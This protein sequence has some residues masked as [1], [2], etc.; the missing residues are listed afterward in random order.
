MSSDGYWNGNFERTWVQVRLADGVI[1][2]EGAFFVPEAYRQTYWRCD[3]HPRYRPDG[4]Q[5]GF[6]S[7]HEGSRQVYVRD[8]Q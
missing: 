3:L 1:K 2:P 7:V 6:N 4:K 5:I 8:I